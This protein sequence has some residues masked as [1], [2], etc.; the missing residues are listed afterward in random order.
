MKNKYIFL[1][2]EECTEKDGI[3]LH[4]YKSLTS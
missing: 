4:F 1:K 3:V 2:K